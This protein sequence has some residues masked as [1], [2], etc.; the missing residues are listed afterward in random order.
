V[1]VSAELPADDSPTVEPPASII[2]ATEIASVMPP[3]DPAGLSQ[4][5]KEHELA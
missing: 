4:A 3:L 1:P 5:A 2:A